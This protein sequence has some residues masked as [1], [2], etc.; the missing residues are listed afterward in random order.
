MANGQSE[1][2]RLVRID[3]LRRC[4]ATAFQRLQLEREDA[5]GL[6]G[7]LL[8]SELRGHPTMGSRCWGCWPPSTATAS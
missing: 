2:T 5:E 7:L 4:L 3:D 8:D 1:G 6:A